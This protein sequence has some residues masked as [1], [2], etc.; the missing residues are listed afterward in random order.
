MLSCYP[1]LGEHIILVRPLLRLIDIH[2]KTQILWKFISLPYHFIFFLKKYSLSPVSGGSISGYL[3]IH[4]SFRSLGCNS[5]AKKFY[6]KKRE[7]K[8][9]YTMEIWNSFIA[10]SALSNAR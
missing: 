1:D 4:F 7:N 8:P 6:E 3:T 2:L 9:V 10:Y 5:E